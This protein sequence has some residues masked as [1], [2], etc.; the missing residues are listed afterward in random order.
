[1]LHDDAGDGSTSTRL[2]TEYRSLLLHSNLGLLFGCGRETTKYTGIVPFWTTYDDTMA[3]RDDSSV[4]GDGG[5]TSIIVVSDDEFARNKPRMLEALND[6]GDGWRSR[7][8][9]FYLKMHRRYQLDP[10][11]S[12]ASLSSANWRD[13]PEELQNDLGFCAR[14]ISAGVEPFS[15]QDK[16]VTAEEF[17]KN[18]TKVPSERWYDILVEASPNLPN[19]RR[20]C[21]AVARSSN[22]NVVHSFFERVAPPAMRSDKEI[23]AVA[24]SMGNIWARAGGAL[25]NDPDFLRDVL[26]LEPKKLANIE[27]A[28]LC[29]FPVLLIEFLPLALR[30][31]HDSDSEDSEYDFLLWIEYM[32]RRIPRDLWNNNR[33]VVR[34]WFK[35]GGRFIKLFHEE[36]KNEPLVALWICQHSLPKSD[37]H[38]L[39]VNF[40]RAAPALL[41]DK[42]FMLK[43][44]ALNADVFHAATDNLQSDFSF[45]LI[46]FGGTPGHYP[47]VNATT[48]PH[49]RR[50]MI[51]FQ[52]R[53]AEELQSHRDFKFLAQQN[54]SV[55]PSDFIADAKVLP[56][57]ERVEKL[58]AAM[59]NIAAAFVRGSSL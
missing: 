50:C 54:P 15:I 39:V 24:C 14:A 40:R 26:N 10:D 20:F 34:A 35:G 36:Y 5:P 43:A 1:M 29:R 12:I 16:D 2:V 38:E 55:L 37:R 11:I 17:L 41:Q 9:L 22:F 23:M 31:V 4:D 42:E 18:L 6:R 25:L 32:A 47:Y 56:T 59:E 33:H 58:Q 44:V 19:D 28:T 8:R 13:I 30:R 3:T 48:W 53:A 7:G 51:Q 49:L 21:L 27:P 46:A 52:T 57:D 45:Q